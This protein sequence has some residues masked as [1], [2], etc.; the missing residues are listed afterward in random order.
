MTVFIITIGSIHNVILSDSVLIKIITLN[1]FIKL[2]S[3]AV[4][5]YTVFPINITE[6]LHLVRMKCFD[7]DPSTCQCGPDCP[8]KFSN[9][10]A[11]VLRGITN[12]HRV[13]M[14]IFIYICIIFH[15]NELHI[16]NLNLSKYTEV[17]NEEAKKML[18]LFR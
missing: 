10:T 2:S 6:S 15:F 17:S 12:Q 7:D 16:I 5:K 8:L 11:I 9:T 14:F 4:C 3:S 18:I 1:N 13:V